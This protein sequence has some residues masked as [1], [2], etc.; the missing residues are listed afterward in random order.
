MNGVMATGTRTT[1][2][3]PA[4]ALGNAQPIETI[5]ERWVSADLQ[6]PV[7][8]KTTDPR[9]GT[10]ITQLTNINRAEPDS[11]L[12]TIPPDYTVT[13]V[14]APGGPGARGPGRPPRGGQIN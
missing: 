7:M 11:S 12:F 5:H 1:R 10:T 14:G 2:T 9:F 8:V 13:H 4:G 3:I 6:V